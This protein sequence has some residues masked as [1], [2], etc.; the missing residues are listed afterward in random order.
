M[1]V[2]AILACVTFNRHDFWKTNGERGAANGADPAELG[3]FSGLVEN[4][5]IFSTSS[6]S[7]VVDALREARAHLLRSNLG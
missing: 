5:N 7:A 2:S 3:W 4:M 1:C 6:S